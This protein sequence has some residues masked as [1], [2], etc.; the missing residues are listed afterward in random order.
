MRTLLLAG[1]LAALLSTPA[2]AEHVQ[3]CNGG[4]VS[5]L[6]GVQMV[7]SASWTFSASC[8]G[9]DLWDK[10]HVQG[11]SKP[12]EPY[13]RPWADTPITVIGY[14][15][16]KLQRDRLSSVFSRYENDRMSWFMIGSGMNSQ[17]D[18]MLWLG[19][20]ETRSRIMWPAGMGQVWPSK[21]RA[22]KAKYED[23]LDLHGK[24]FGG[25]PITIHLTIYYTPHR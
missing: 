1:L 23:I 22:R 6:D 18:A 2:P 4:K 20:G 10:W 11:Q 14:E 17:P 25:A 12:D 15:L 7:C 9:E 3:T 13:I 19:P 24:C 8:T 16:V 5:V 21:D